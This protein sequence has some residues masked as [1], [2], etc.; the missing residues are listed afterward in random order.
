MP[1]LDFKRR[2]F[3]KSIGSGSL[4]ALAGCL[5]GNGGGGNGSDDTTN[6]A[7][8][9]PVAGLGDQG[10]SDNAQKGLM[11]AENELGISYSEG[12]PS[13]NSEYSD[14][15]NQFA[16]S[17]DPDY[18]LIIG[19]TFA[20]VTP[21]EQ[22][23]SDFPD[24]KWTLIDAPVEGRDNVSSVFFSE[25]EGSYLAGT[26]AGYFATEGFESETT[27][28][29]GNGVV[30][31]VGGGRNPVIERFQAGYRA[32]VK[33]F[34]ESIEVRSAYAGAFNKPGQGRSIAQSM[35]GEGADVVYHAAGGTGIGMF[36]AAQEAGRPAI[37][38]DTDQSKTAS[39]YKDVIVASMIKRMDTAVFTAIEDVVEG[40]YDGGSIVR[41]GLADDAHE[42]FYGQSIG[43]AVPDAAREKV[44]EVRQKIID[45]DITP[46]ETVDG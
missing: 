35:Y 11:Q 32:G 1:Q 45:G 19:L 40:E 30:G 27:S 5:G 33:A 23:S 4:V 8:V 15:H 3:V 10:F 7:M 2:T 12:E 29:P 9:Y 22:V 20:Q 43:S 38:V 25:H 41:L 6:V 26:L 18:D 13:S 21:I 28:A 37:G 46:P 44:D 36:E 31:F 34:D 24:Q 39:D 16:S 42:L 14:F 17:Q